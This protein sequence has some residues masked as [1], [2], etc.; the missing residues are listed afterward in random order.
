[1]QASKL[2]A[3]ISALLATA[4]EDELVEVVVELGPAE[5]LAVPAG[6]SRSEAIA[7]ARSRFEERAAPVEVSVDRAGG[8]VLERAWINQTLKVRLKPQ[9]LRDLSDLDEVRAVDTTRTLTA[10]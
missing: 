1:M 6:S 7:A 2:S 4:G 10:D 9:A 3:G 8:R 5:R